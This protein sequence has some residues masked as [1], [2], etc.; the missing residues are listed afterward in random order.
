MINQR[1]IVN[2]GI[3]KNKSWVITKEGEIPQKVI[4][5]DQNK[6]FREVPSYD[7]RLSTNYR[8]FFIGDIA[9]KIASRTG[10]VLRGSSLND[11][12]SRGSS[13]GSSRGFDKD[14]EKPEPVRSK[15]RQSKFKT[16]FNHGINLEDLEVSQSM[17][18]KNPTEIQNNN[19]LLYTSS[20]RN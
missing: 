14:V 1:M 8:K 4:I 3:P 13:R 9:K 18:R 12:F 10:K 11:S 16:E 15:L 20:A 17:V 19:K 2:A 7:Y 6:K 5:F